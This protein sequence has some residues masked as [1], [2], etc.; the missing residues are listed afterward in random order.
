MKIEKILV[1]L[2]LSAMAIT[3][4]PKQDKV[5]KILEDNV[6]GVLQKIMNS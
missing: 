3:C 2:L 4:R 1:F 6:A 5:T